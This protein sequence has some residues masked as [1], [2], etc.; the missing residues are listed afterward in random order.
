MTVSD[1]LELVRYNQFFLERYYHFGWRGDPRAIAVYHRV[2]SSDQA[3]SAIG[4]LNALLIVMAQAQQG[5]DRVLPYLDGAMIDS[6][7][8]HLGRTHQWLVAEETIEC[9]IPLTTC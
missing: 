3:R 5:W 6:K 8:W 4:T 1:A 9:L 2:I 7:S